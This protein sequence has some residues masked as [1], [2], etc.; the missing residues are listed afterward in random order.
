MSFFDEQHLPRA[1]E[2][3]ARYPQAKSAILPLAHLAQDQHGWLSPEAIAEIG[4]LTGTTAADVLGT[5]S[6]YTMFKRRPCGRLLVSEIGR[7]HV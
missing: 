2:I 5:T 7:A 3:V 4:D 1:R 6:F